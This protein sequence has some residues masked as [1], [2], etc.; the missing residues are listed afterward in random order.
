[1]NNLRIKSASVRFSCAD[2]TARLQQEAT[3]KALHRENEFV[4]SKEGDAQERRAGTADA[5]G[6]QALPRGNQ[7]HGDSP[8]AGGMDASQVP[9]VMHSDLTMLGYQN[10]PLEA[11]PS[12]RVVRDWSHALLPLS[13]LQAGSWMAT[14]THATYGFD[15]STKLGDHVA[16]LIA[17]ARNEGKKR[18]SM[19][20]GGCFLTHS[21]AEAGLA[22]M[23]EHG[24]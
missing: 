20:L 4:V 1:L 16:V 6:Q 17:S 8:P 9:T 15:A 14:Q 3:E 13:D 21:T 19:M 23:L 5:P 7:T 24:V 12:A 11:L 2:A 22:D 18:R 10:L